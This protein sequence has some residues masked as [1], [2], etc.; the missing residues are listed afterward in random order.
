[1]LLLQQ[2]QADLRRYLTIKG[3]D[4]SNETKQRKDFRDAKLELLSLFANQQSKWVVSVPGPSHS[5]RHQQ[6]DNDNMMM[7]LKETIEKDGGIK[8]LMST[9]RLLAL[10]PE[11][12]DGK[13]V[14]AV[15][16]IHK[17]I[18]DG[19]LDIS[20]FT[21]KPGNESLERRTRSWMKYLAEETLKL[22]LPEE[23][24]LN[25]ALQQ[26]QHVNRGEHYYYFSSTKEAAYAY[27]KLGEID[28][29]RL[30]IRLN[31][32]EKSGKE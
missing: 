5:N 28:A 29:V 9:C 14:E 7:S 18:R 20:S 8:E 16:L 15:Q 32:E 4:A 30:V 24:K 25:A 2:Q 31:E 27:T 13:G 1:L 11:D 6:D 17:G 19:S 3:G 21:L 23:E 10:E 12:Y 22:L 26:E